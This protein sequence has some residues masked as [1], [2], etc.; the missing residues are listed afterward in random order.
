MRVENLKFMSAVL[1]IAFCFF[2]SCKFL[3]LIIY[4][5]ESEDRMKYK[6]DIN[7]RRNDKYNEMVALKYLHVEIVV[8][9]IGLLWKF[10]NKRF[11]TKYYERNCVPNVIILWLKYLKTAI[12]R[13][14]YVSFKCSYASQQII[15][16]WKWT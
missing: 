14:N 10:S 6:S 8:S 1:Y 3:L 12:L 5:E 2:R 7:E 16:G 13:L 15:F 4:S 11:L 9:L